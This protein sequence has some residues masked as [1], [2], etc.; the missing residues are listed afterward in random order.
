MNELRGFARQHWLRLQQQW[1]EQVR[2]RMACWGLLVLLIINLIALSGSWKSSRQQE[3]EQY[4]VELKKMQE[5]ARQSYW[6]DRAIQAEERLAQFQSHLWRAPNASLARANVQAWLDRE[7]K[8]SGLQ[9][10]RINV[11]EP[12][13]FTGQKD[14]RI[15]VQ[16]RGRF[17]AASYGKLLYAIEGAENWISIDSVDLNNGLSPA[18]NLQLSFHF[19]P[20]ERT[21]SSVKR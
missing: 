12:L 10:P 1:Q 21:V 19:V 3:Y 11:L 17:E 20:G 5:L 9:E 4:A 8:S 18:L 6:P 16:L 7:V 2:L 15:E 13:D 14:A